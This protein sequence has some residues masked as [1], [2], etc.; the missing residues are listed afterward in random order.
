MTK[1]ILLMAIVVGI[2]SPTIAETTRNIESTPTTQ[3]DR[4]I[5]YSKRGNG[6][7]FVSTEA[8]TESCRHGYFI[9]KASAGYEGTLSLL[10]AA[11]QTKTPI[12]LTAYT[13]VLW[14]G[15]EASVCEL[16]NITYP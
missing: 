10:L 3:I 11:Y 1:L 8:N 7:V 14:S 15:S 9:D 13:N 6:D 5:V 16:Y 2:V 4:L 12:T